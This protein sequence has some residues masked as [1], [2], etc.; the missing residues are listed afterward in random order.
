MSMADLVPLLMF[1]VVL[2]QNIIS[3][4]GTDCPISLS[5]SKFDNGILWAHSLL[6]YFTLHIRYT[7][8]DTVG[9]Q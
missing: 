5:M 7:Q 6:I 2:I 8:F 3:D 9:N 4:G 1:R